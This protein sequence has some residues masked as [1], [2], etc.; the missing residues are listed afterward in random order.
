M[1]EARNI[2]LTLGG[3]PALTD[4][5]LSLSSG[6]ITAFVGP[7]GAGKSSL[8]NCL[9]GSLR[10][11]RGSAFLDGAPVLNIGAEE[12]ARRRAVLEQEPVSQAPFTVAELAE[13]S[14]PIDVS[15]VD[16]SRLRH[17]AIV[18]VGLSDLS[19]RSILTLSGG[20]RHRAHMARALT[21]L[22]AGELT[23]GTPGWLLL[24]EPT[25]SLDP[26]HQLTILTAAKRATIAGSGVLIVSHDL[27]LAA[28]MADRI[29]LMR[30]GRVVAFGAPSEILTESVLEDVYETKMQINRLAQG[31][32]AVGPCY[33]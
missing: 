17:N 26:R 29:A 2:G 32:W 15:P 5:D 1:L 8:L 16:A 33:S 10:P 23:S 4:V 11:D 13:L 3:R 19:D 18:A 28:N 21:Q 25:S 27:T 24:D 14:T 6:E 9:A 12:L 7:N 31:D 20:E 22:A 30:D